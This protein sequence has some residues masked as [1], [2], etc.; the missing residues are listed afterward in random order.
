MNSVTPTLPHA[1]GATPTGQASTCRAN[2]IVEDNIVIP[3]WI[4]S[5]AAYRQWAE[6]DAYPSS[7][8]IS[9]LNGTI[10]VDASMEEFL[11]HNQIKQAF[12]GM[13]YMLLTQHA[14][15]RWVPDRMLLVNEAANLSTEPDGLFFF[16]ATMKSERLRLVPGQRTGYMQLEGSPDIVLEIVSMKS[17]TKDLKDLRE[18]Y[19]KAQIPEYWL[20]D[21]R[22]E[23]IC[24]DIL[25]YTTD[26]YEPAP[27]DDGWVRSNVLERAFRIERSIDPLGM[28]QFV[29][30]MKSDLV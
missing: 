25:R 3:G 2:V 30:H 6:S 4:D 1:A 13:F 11:S 5:L 21:A 19:G 15:G 26:G 27:I 14:V 16:W 29:V 18:L 20:V 17:K 23:N 8:W 7:G 28:P 24:F 10:W 12:N 22:H 9:Y